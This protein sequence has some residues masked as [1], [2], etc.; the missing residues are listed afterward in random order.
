[1]NSNEQGPEMDD[2]VINSLAQLTNASTV[3]HKPSASDNPESNM[4]LEKHEPHYKVP[5]QEIQIHSPSDIE[6]GPDES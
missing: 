2:Q 4:A 3:S 1:M 6:L 5:E